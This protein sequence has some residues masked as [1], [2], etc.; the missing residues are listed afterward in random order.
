VAA[1]MPAGGQHALRGELI[2]TMLKQLQS[3]E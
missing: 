1:L 2:P 3:R